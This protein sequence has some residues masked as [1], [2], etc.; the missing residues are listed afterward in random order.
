[1]ALLHEEDFF[2]EKADGVAF[3]VTV[4]FRPEQTYLLPEPEEPVVDCEL[5]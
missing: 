4:A 5:R 3:G 2:L 1:M